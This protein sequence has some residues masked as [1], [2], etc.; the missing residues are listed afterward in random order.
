MSFATL[1]IKSTTTKVDKYDNCVSNLTNQ[2]F[3][4]IAAIYFYSELCND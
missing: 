1:F 2:F 4:S 3:F